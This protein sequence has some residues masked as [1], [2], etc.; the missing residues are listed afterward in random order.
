MVNVSYK[1]DRDILTI[2]CS[3]S[4][5]EDAQIL[6]NTVAEVFIE[7]DR[8]WNA[9]ES[10]KLKYFLEEQKS[11]KKAQLDSV[12]NELMNFLPYKI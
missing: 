1:R 9:E 8:K 7:M 10:I 12:E 5:P 2:E 4:F 11:I 3:S 6:A